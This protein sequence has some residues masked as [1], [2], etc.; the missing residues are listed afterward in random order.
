VCRLARTGRGL[1]AA[2]SDAALLTAGEYWI[3]YAALME[4]RP[5]RRLLAVA[6]LGVYAFLYTPMVVVAIFS[7]ASNR[8]SALPIRG[9]TLDWYRGVL[10]NGEII[11]A[12]RNSV[13]VAT[14]AVVVAV[15]FG[16]PGALL[17]DRYDF[18]G[19]R[20]FQ[21]FVLLPLI[22]P[23]V[24][25]GVSFLMFF[26][27]LGIP[28][29]LW[30]VILG[31]GTALISTVVTTVYARLLRFDRSIEEASMDLGVTRWRTFWRVVFPNIR[32]SILAAALLSFTL[33]MDEIP[34]T[35]FIIGNQNTLP[36]AIWSML[37]RGFTPEINAIS[38]V[39][40]LVGV[41]TVA[42]FSYL[43][44]GEARTRAREGGSL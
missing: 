24:I 34:V 15:V 10:A 5:V 43:T 4:D 9:L 26:H 19:K 12:L 3:Q 2:T 1:H 30:T 6:S 41:G 44:E 20:L 8:V 31:H 40:L 7:F 14:M 18:P 38:T 21:R 13:F 29:S 17:I 32:I 36:I 16:V 35:F 39:V 23:G 25:T 11:S 22:L 28:L 27:A 33:S 37:R 42:L